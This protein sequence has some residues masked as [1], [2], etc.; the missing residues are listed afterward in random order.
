MAMAGTGLRCAAGE[1]RR[2]EMERFA[3]QMQD[4]TSIDW[5]YSAYVYSRDST[6]DRFVLEA[7]RNLIFPRFQ[8]DPA[9]L[10]GKS[11]VKMTSFSGARF[12]IPGC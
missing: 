6:T 2:S 8:Q 1:I 11:G 3:L 7:W 9:H 5:T 4:V 12:K 10:V